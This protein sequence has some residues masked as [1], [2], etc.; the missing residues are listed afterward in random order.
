MSAVSASSDTLQ[1]EISSLD[2]RIEAILPGVWIGAEPTFTLRNSEQPEWLSE[3]LGGEKEILAQR[4]MRLLL[5]RHPGALVLRTLGRQYPGEPLPR[6]SLGLYASRDGKSLW[7]GSRDP[8]DE[9]LPALP[10]ERLLAFMDH[11]LHGLAMKGWSTHPFKCQGSLPHRLVFRLDDK[12]LMHGEEEL[13]RWSRESRHEQPIPPS[14]LEDELAARGEYLLALGPHTGHEGVDCAI[15]ELPAFPDVRMFRRFLEVLEPAA[16]YLPGLIL[17]GYPPPVDETVVWTTLT[18]DPAVIEINQAPYPD[19]RQFHAA[20]REL[21]GVCEKVGLSTYRLQYNGVESD[22]GGGGQ[23]TLGGRTP[24]L[25]PFLTNRHLLPRLIRYW[26]AHPALSYWFAPDYLGGTSQSPRPDEGL[27][28]LFHELRLA[29]HLLKHEKDPD[30][31]FLWRSLAPFLTDPSGN[32]HRSDLN[33][34]KLWNPYLPGRGC[35]GLVEF[36]AFRMAGSAERSTALGLLLRALV[37]MLSR[38][39]VTPDLL[40]WGDTLHRRFALPFFLKQDLQQVCSDLQQVGLGLGPSLERCLMLDPARTRWKVTFEGCQLE[41]ERA[42][43]FWPLVGG[44]AEG[45]EQGGSRWVDASTARWQV[46]LR[47]ID[48]TPQQ[49]F[50]EWDV[51]W[52]GFSLPLREE[53]DG[54]GV[55]RLCAI[56]LREFEPWIGLHPGVKPCMPLSLVLRHPAKPSALRLRIH[57]WQPEGL[58]YPGLPKDRKDAERR[59]EERLTRETVAAGSLKLPVAPPPESL[60]DYGVDLRWICS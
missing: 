3:A 42:L 22:S 29:L 18:P 40:D 2:E 60:D 41:L 44:D 38:E 21:F 28:N 54:Q 57:G 36:R 4:L 11:L 14:G 23:L 56:R 58:P 59:R 27:R 9:E 51:E 1:Q 10:P 53:T 5:E 43:E 30:S 6:W 55:V 15:L 49:A 12:P 50:S 19:S 16:K 47:P 45:Q 48:G 32:S 34:E 25:S 52:N 17:Q 7:Q 13:A 31:E 8:L 24:N 26:V 35:L 39:D 46:L 33:I 37:A 20:S